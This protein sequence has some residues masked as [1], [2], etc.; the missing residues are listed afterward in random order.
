MILSKLQ[1]AAE[2]FKMNDLVQAERLY[3]EMIISQPEN[4]LAYLGMGV[5]ALKVQ[6][7]DKAVSFLTKSCELLP[8]EAQPL[9]KLSEAF[10]GVNSEIDG[11]TAL[12][13]AANHLPNSAVVHYH[14]G[15]Q[16][17]MLGD[18]DKGEQSFISVIQLT[19][20]PITSFALFELTRLDRHSEQYLPIIETRLKQTQMSSQ[21]TTVLHYALGNVLH[22]MQNYQQAWHH[23][24]SANLLQAQLCS[25]K[26]IELEDFFQEIKLNATKQV[27]S[28]RRAVAKSTKEIIPIFILGLPRTGSTL[29]EQ[30]LT[31][32]QDISSAGEAPYLSGEV[33]GFLFSQSK[34]HYPYSMADITDTQL[35]TAAQIYLDKMSLHA[36]NEGYVIDKLPA[37]FQSIGLIYKLFPKAKVLHIK[38]NLADVALSIYRNYFAQNEPY[39]CSLREFKQYHTLYTDLMAYWNMQLPGFIHEVSYEQLVENKTDTIKSILDFCDL[40][41]PK[42]TA[43]GRK[44][45]KVVKTLSNIQVRGAI[46]TEAIENWHNYA[47]HLALFT[48]SEHAE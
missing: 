25:F 14:L 8:N 27:L 32:H 46:S 45:N 1:Q 11:L 33:A 3:K 24:D 2:L 43:S 36:S 41:L 5:I 23:F 28:K 48:E 16:Y 35:N 12:E 20:D 22:G 21:E 44:I 15:L 30:L 9:I 18:L 40:S 17:I 38:R 31:E 6:Q 7:F 4:G 29:L 42:Y 26:T 37:N 19:Q 34:L 47:E 13:Y 39:F 10:N